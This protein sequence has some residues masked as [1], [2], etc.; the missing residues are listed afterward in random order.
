MRLHKK[1][2]LLLGCVGFCFITSCN[3]FLSPVGSNLLG[4]LSEDDWSGNTETLTYDGTQVQFELSKGVRILNIQA[5]QPVDVFMAKMNFS[6]QVLSAYSTRYIVSTDR[7][8]GENQF[9]LNSSENSSYKNLPFDLNSL[10]DVSGITTS[11]IIRKDFALARDFVPPVLNQNGAASRSAGDVFPLQSVAE[12]SQK[13]VKNWQKDDTKALWI[14]VPK[15]RGTGIIDSSSDGLYTQR[16]AT[17]RAIGQNCY[18]WVVSGDG[19]RL[20]ISETQADNLVKKFDYMYSAIRE[21]FG[22]ESDNI[23]HLSGGQE[24]IVPISD[25]SD[26]ETKVNI[27]VYDIGGD[28]KVGQQSGVVGYFWPKDY[29]SKAIDTTKMNSTSALAIALTNEGKYFYVDSGFL[30]EYE[31]IVYSTLAHEFQHMVNFGE[32]TMSSMA[33]ATMSSSV[34]NCSTWF[35]EM[36]SMVCEDMVQQYLDIKN[37]DSSIGRLVTFAQNYYGSGLTDWLNGNYVI[38]SYAGAYAFGAYLA[39][40]YG[41]TELIKEIATNAAV[42]QE[43]ITQAL[44]VLGINENFESVF[45][46]YAQALVLDNPPSDKVPSFN[47]SVKGIGGDM[48]AINLFEDFIEYENGKKYP[49]RPKLLGFNENSRVA[50]RPYGFS[51]HRVGSTDSTGTLSLTFSRQVNDNER[52]YI[53]VQPSKQ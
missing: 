48:K 11:G 44:N 6:S 45:E 42:D 52:V 29:Y 1:I 18:V 9:S 27:V 53:L 22:S 5:N 25:V 13:A 35:T 31:S 47:K 28:Y 17:L 33:N 4:S 30:Q 12:E 15:N 41:G 46:K 7:F 21:V 14:D 36:L 2:A 39:R 49:L 8:V 51:L 3:N 43:A 37:E 40:N 32:K 38:W 10:K 50:L 20:T 24:I 26:T 16:R 23:F 19:S 34:L